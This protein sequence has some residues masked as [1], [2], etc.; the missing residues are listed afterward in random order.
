[1]QNTRFSSLTS[2]TVPFTF[3]EKE[4]LKSNVC[5]PKPVQKKP[6]LF[7]V[8][9]FSGNHLYL[10]VIVFRTTVRAGIFEIYRAKFCCE[11]NRC[12]RG[13]RYCTTL[14]YKG[15]HAT[16]LYFCGTDGNISE[17]ENDNTNSF[18]HEYRFKLEGMYD[19]FYT[20]AGKEMVA[21]RKKA[22]ADFYHS[23]LTE[24]QK[25]TKTGSDLLDKQIQV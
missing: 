7:C 12:D 20:Q 18:F 22:A 10:S 14:A 13:H 17:R 16:P 5:Q 1:M 24:V 2:D 9:M 21:I 11:T 6:E 3:E 23:M 8:N 4:H 25:I 15:Q 19:R